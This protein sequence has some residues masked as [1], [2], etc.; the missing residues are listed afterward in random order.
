MYF[1]LGYIS[2]KG[3]FSA[4]CC[5]LA[6]HLCPQFETCLWFRVQIF[7]IAVAILILYTEVECGFQTRSD[8]TPVVHETVMQGNCFKTFYLWTPQMRFL[9]F[10]CLESWLKYREVELRTLV[11]MGKHTLAYT[12]ENTSWENHKGS[13]ELFF[14]Y[15]VC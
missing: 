13:V 4:G 7:W 9:N 11:I 1:S 14:L 5:Q 10:I 12:A 15:L 8:Y 3:V 2:L 6:I